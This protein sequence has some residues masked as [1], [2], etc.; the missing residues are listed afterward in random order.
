[1]VLILPGCF[2]QPDCLINNTNILKITLKGKTLGKDTTVAFISIRDIKEPAALYLNQA[3]G[4]IQIPVQI[5]DTVTTVVF[6]Y[7]E[8]SLPVSDT[9]VVAY[10]NQTRVISPDCGAYLYQIDVKIPKTNFEKTKVTNSI[11]STSATKNLEI[12]L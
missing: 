6:E 3:L 4:S 2:E 10:Q 8:K 7:T 5:N 11:L 12:F 1:M 9:L